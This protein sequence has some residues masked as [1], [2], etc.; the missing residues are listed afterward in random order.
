MPHSRTN[1]FTRG[2]ARRLVELILT[3][4]N[5]KLKLH[6]IAVFSG[7]SEHYLKYLFKDHV[8]TPPGRFIK[9]VYLNYA[10]QELMS[11]NDKIIVIALNAGYGSQQS[12][13]RAFRQKYR[14]TPTAFRELTAEAAAGVL[15]H[16]RCLLPESG[17]ADG[18]GRQEMAV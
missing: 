1:G 13:S 8:G 12:F 9:D 2:V 10:A 15:H 4:P 16:H 17:S 6:D 7:Y 11:T 5:N 18:E 3:R 14:L